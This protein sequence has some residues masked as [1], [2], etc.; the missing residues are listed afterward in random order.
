MLSLDMDII[1]SNNS[2]WI[3]PTIMPVFENMI[4]GWL[5]HEMINSEGSLLLPSSEWSILYSKC[6]SVTTE[7]SLVVIQLPPKF[8]RPKKQNIYIPPYYTNDIDEGVFGFQKCRNSVYRPKQTW[9]EVSCKILITFNHEE[10]N[11]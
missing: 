9:E 3:E 7:S 11:E 4:S 10:H 2:Y 1:E 5:I 8:W 6:E